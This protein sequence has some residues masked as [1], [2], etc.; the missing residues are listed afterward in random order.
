[1]RCDFRPQRRK[2]QSAEPTVLMRVLV[3]AEREVLSLRRP[4][5]TQE[6]IPGLLKMAIVAVLRMLERC[7]TPVAYWG[8]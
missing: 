7:R 1:M 2:T 8:M 4:K 6:I 3:E 5:P